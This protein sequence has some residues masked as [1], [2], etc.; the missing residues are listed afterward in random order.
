MKEK[1]KFLKLLNE[2]RT[3]DYELQY[4]KEVLKDGHLEFEEYYRVWC[5]END[6]DI[7]QLNK[8]NQKKV[9]QIF[10][11]KETSQL[12]TQVIQK[13][14]A[15]K[16]DFKKL[17]KE[18][19][20]TLHPDK[21]DNDDPRKW[22]YSE[23]FKKANAAKSSAKWGELFDIVDKYDIWIGEYDEAIDSLREDII[24][25]NA[26]IKKEKSTY[27]WLLHEAETKQQKDQVVKNFLRQLFGWK[28]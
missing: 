26:E 23:A 16:R 15:N 14:E 13:L 12:S 25:I 28:G 21:L 10:E 22:E 1:L 17:F 7:D 3:L 20:K 2:F 6:V 11:K 18:I 8:D 9:A 27:S 5:A 24:R 19:A 4:I